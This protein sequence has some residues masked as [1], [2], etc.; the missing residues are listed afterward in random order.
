MHVL[1]RYLRRAGY[2]SEEG[3]P[4]DGQLPERFVA[5][6]EEAAFEEL[7]R[8]HGPMVLG[9]CDRRIG[10]VRDHLGQLDLFY[11]PATLIIRCLGFVLLTRVPCLLFSPI[12]RMFTAGSGRMADV[13]FR[14]R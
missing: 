1:L 9:V 5:Q 3:Q 8:R 4:T 7:V 12:C 10:A 14:K 6:R 2:F 13:T 11:L